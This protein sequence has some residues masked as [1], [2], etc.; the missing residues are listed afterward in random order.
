[1]YHNNNFNHVA[2]F[3]KL[4]GICNNIGARYNPGNA[5]I[6]PTAL[7]ALLE[8]AQQ[9]SKA[10][11]DAQSAHTLAVNAR[12]EMFDG[13]PTFITQLVRSTIAHGTSAENT[14]DL[15][16][17]K[18]KFYR[19]VAKKMPKASPS[20]QSEGGRAHHPGHYKT[21]DARLA[22]FSSIV[23]IIES[24]PD[25]TPN[26]PE[27]KIEGLHARLSALKATMATVAKT[28]NDLTTARINRDEIYFGFNGIS[29]TSQ[30]VKEY[31]RSVTGVRSQTSQALGKI[32]IRRKHK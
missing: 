14:R 19:T 25:Y 20:I 9:R 7:G 32:V 1:M 15:K 22:H 17:L 2:S 31:V 12:K 13:L 5:S 18:Q 11:T 27:L 28:A 8:Q 23:S 30:M 24:I 10:V 26:E 4:L 29:A 6:T 16:L 21:F 3:E